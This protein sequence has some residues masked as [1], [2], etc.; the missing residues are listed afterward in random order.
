MSEAKPR[1]RWTRWLGE[2]VF[3]LVILLGIQWWQ[4]RDLMPADGRPAPQVQLLDLEDRPVS[5]ADF[6]GMRVQLHFWATWC[7]V[8]RMEHGALNAV[9]DG[10][11]K[12]QKLVAIVADGQDVE[13]L[14]SYIEEQGIRYP[15]L[16][17]DDAA[18]KAFGV[19]QF[20]TNYFLSPDGTLSANDVGWSTRWG[21]RARL[22]GCL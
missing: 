13:K 21:M 2:I 19:K 4:R 14:K 9:H 17:A 8:C 5:L 22:S 10:L 7:G 3:F 6:K 16:R 20:P 12:D 11:G 18:L 1:R 15:V